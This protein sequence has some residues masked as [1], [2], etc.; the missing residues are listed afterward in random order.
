MMRLEFLKVFPLV[1]L[2][3]F[4][5]FQVDFGRIYIESLLYTMQFNRYR[6]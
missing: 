4:H 2:A 5:G 6:L 1:M 3:L